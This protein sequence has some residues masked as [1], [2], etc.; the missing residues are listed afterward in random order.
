MYNIRRAWEHVI[1]APLKFQLAPG[2]P[3][4]RLTSYDAP[5]FIAFVSFH[6]PPPPPGLPRNP[7]ARASGLV[8][9]IHYYYTSR[10]RLAHIPRQSK[11]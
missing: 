2:E 10:Q 1:R 6:P 5:P 11:R 7:V 8:Q 4:A 9:M 3:P